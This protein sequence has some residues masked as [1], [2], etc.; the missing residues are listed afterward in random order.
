MTTAATAR[1]VIKV[2]N[3]NDD[4]DGSLREAIRQGNEAV[5]AGKSVEIAFT[6]SF[7]IKAKTG[8]SLEKG[9]WTFNQ[10]LTKDI[11]IDGEEASGPLFQI[12]NQSNIN[13][14]T[15]TSDIDELK[16]DIT[17][18]HLINSHVKGGDGKSG[19]GGGLGTGSALLHFNGHVTWSESSFQGNTVEGGR[20]ALGAKGGQAYYIHDKDKSQSAKDGER[21]QRGGNFNASSATSHSNNFGTGGKRGGADSFYGYFHRKGSGIAGKNGL[22]GHNGKL[23]GEAG[24]GGGGGGGGTYQPRPRMGERDFSNRYEGYKGDG[25]K[26]GNGG[27]G[28]NGGDGTFGAG[29]GTGGSAGANAGNDRYWAHTGWPFWRWYERSPSWT[30]TN[31][32][33][34]N[35][36][37]GEWASAPTRAGDP[38][39]AQSGAAG[40]GGDGAA[41]GVIS[42]LA[43]KSEKSSLTFKNVDFRK[44]IAKGG[45]QTGRFSNIYSRYLNVKYNNLTNSTGDSFRGGEIGNGQFE[46]NT[47]NSTTDKSRSY[48]NSGRFSEL[49]LPRSIAPQE[50]W[51]SSYET[52]S[53]I[54]QTFGKTYELGNSLGHTI[55]L[56]A[57]HK[58]TSVQK[59]EIEG[60]EALLQSVR[61]VNNLANKT[62]SEDEI[63]STHKGILGSLTSTKAFSPASK[64]A[65][66]AIEK[67][68]DKFASN[69]GLETAKKYSKYALGAGALIGE[70]ILNQLA[71]DARIEKELE[72]KRRIDQGRKTINQLIPKQLKITPFD[73]GSKRTFDTF[74]NFKVGG[75]QINFTSRITPTITYRIDPATGGIID[76][77]ST[78]TDQ[79][80]DNSARLIGQ[81]RLSKEQTANA[82]K[83]GN[84]TA[85]FQQF[86]HLGETNGKAHY[87]FA[88]DS[89]WQ[90][91]SR[92]LDRKPGGIGND[93]IIIRRADGVKNDTMLTV[94]GFDG[95]DRIQGDS[96]NSTLIGERGND[97]FD[98]GTGSDI[99]KG[100]S[101]T[102]T[103]SYISQKSAVSIKTSTKSKEI[104]VTNSTESWTDK[105]SDIEILRT[106][107]GSNHTLTNAKRSSTQGHGYTVQTGATG[108]TK[109]SQ[110]D[111]KLLISYASN[112]NTDPAKTTL[113][114]ATIVDGQKGKDSLLID[115]LA[116]H[117]KSGQTFRLTY[118]DNSKSRGFITKTTNSGNAKILKFSGINKGLTLTD[119]QR[120]SQGL[121]TVK[122]LTENKTGQANADLSDIDADE[123]IGS[124]SSRQDNFD[125]ESDDLSGA[126]S[127]HFS[128]S[129]IS[130]YLQTKALRLPVAIGT[131]NTMDQ[132][133]T[134]LPEEPVQSTLASTLSMDHTAWEPG[135]DRQQQPIW[136]QKE[137]FIDPLA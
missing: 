100:G 96:G 93:R 95:H 64:A 45:E 121:L 103:A 24:G 135:Q 128:H 111:D 55:V 2:T 7:H 8:Y 9:D 77:T 17:R 49:K 31:K 15:K 90:Y 36:R 92:P 12:G 113:K 65:A 81:I 68:I 28:G 76:I 34:A 137:F 125:I 59:L 19:G 101:G 115:G 83:I 102:D 107:G 82:K 38:N 85:Y 112:Y 58:D 11:I 133:S 6:S 14:S 1:K 48:A 18:M 61:K 108:T 75:D 136:A 98:P 117:I 40:R 44:N 134:T 91:Y 109:G 47:N 5:K 89:Q 29:G 124:S 123:L 105:L 66:G 119:T 87:V 37:S 60:A 78:R 80:S 16:V 118:S 71:E 54:V 35:G 122:P 39:R 21:G 114:K 62:K 131:L 3:N 41:L 51:S 116:A 4:G 110:Y 70:T 27:R 46:R 32:Q 97:F 33:G 50:I 106:W 129:N 42:S 79:V 94:N 22:K 127:A 10:N 67:K 99:V 86:L 13:S 88:K 130:D 126:S 53:S 63:R 56:H 20:G 73:L 43:T 25:S 84:T 132:V 120:N 26:W 72:E 23:F 69:F 52:N 74:K 30:T 57:D 104:N